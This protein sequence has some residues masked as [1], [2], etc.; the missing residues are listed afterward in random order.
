MESSLY[1]SIYQRVSSEVNNDEHFCTYLAEICTDSDSHC[2]DLRDIIDTM[3][4]TSYPNMSDARRQHVIYSLLD[5][6]EEN[7]KKMNEVTDDN[8]NDEDDIDL[9]ERVERDGECKL[10]GSNQRITIH[11]LIPKLILKRMRNSGKESVDVSKYLIEVCRPCHNEIHRIWPHNEL[12]KEYQT[13][14]MI[15]DAPAIQ[16]YLNWKRKRERTA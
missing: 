2:D 5:L 9:S 13:V 8:V 7:R 6:I 12:A 11:H 3:F 1:N 14:D 10:C 16:P 15:L 4:K